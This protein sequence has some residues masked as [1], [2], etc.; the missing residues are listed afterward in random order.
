MALNRMTS[1]FRKAALVACAA[2]LTAGCETPLPCDGP[3]NCTGN[4]CCFDFPTSN[5]GFGP[6]VYCTGAADACVPNVTIDTRTTRLCE[7]DADC[8]AGGISTVWDTCCPS[9]VMN[10]AAKT[11]GGPCHRPGD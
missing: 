6:A 5:L 3:S 4:A 2:V 1:D 8:V 7:T 9:S 11:C 10:R